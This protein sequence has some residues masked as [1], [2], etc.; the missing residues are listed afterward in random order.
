MGRD[1]ICRISL[2]SGCTRCRCGAGARDYALMLLM[3]RTSIR[4]AEACSLKLSDKTVES[5][6]LG[7]A[8]E[9]QGS[10]R[11]NHSIAGR[12]EGSR[13]RV[14]Q[15]GPRPPAESPQRWPEQFIFQPLVYYR[16]LEFAKALST[17]QAWQIVRRWGTTPG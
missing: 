10:E 8:G 7:L 2:T 6:A 15:I 17:T 9:G 12:C 11:A 1:G 3:L 16:T 5:W 14:S 4:V 13:G